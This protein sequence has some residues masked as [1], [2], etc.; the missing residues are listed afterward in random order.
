MGYQ[1]KFWQNS[2]EDWPGGAFESLGTWNPIQKEEKNVRLESELDVCPIFVTRF[3]KWYMLR[4]PAGLHTTLAILMS[5][6]ELQIIWNVATKFKW[7]VSR[8]E[9]HLSH[10]WHFQFLSETDL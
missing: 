4:E 9:N 5:S 8:G 1:S 2:E 7:L 3:M 6:T 10:E